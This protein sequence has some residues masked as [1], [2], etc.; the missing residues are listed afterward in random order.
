MTGHPPTVFIIDDDPAARQSVAALAQSKGVATEV[1]SS[2]EQFLASNA[3]E[4]PGCVVSDFRMEGISGLQLQDE[5]A[6]RGSS[7]PLVIITAYADV[8][9]AV[10]ALQRGALTLLEKPTQG[11]ELWES[12]EQALRTDAANREKAARQAA[13]RRQLATITPDERRVLD[14]ILAGQPNKAMASQLGIGLRTVELRRATLL[15][16]L[17]VQSVAELVRVVLLAT[18]SPPGSPP[19]AGPSR[20]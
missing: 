1:F 2:A 13:T 9:L 18:E 19:E 20:S 16:K 17:N 3:F 10:K 8:P 11:Q 7:L 5:L 4:R 6:R 14:L 12:I 15:R